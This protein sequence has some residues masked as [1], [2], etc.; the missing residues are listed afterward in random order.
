MKRQYIE[1]LKKGITETAL[2]YLI[3]EVQTYGYNIIKE[4]E[5]R[6]TGYLKLKGGTIYPALQRLELKGLVKSWQQRSGGHRARR[7]YR[8]T[9]KGRQFLSKRL[10]EWRDFSLAVSTLMGIGEAH[11]A[12]S[13]ETA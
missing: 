6:T 11:K 9:D 8:I 5:K 1:Q 13:S 2:L 12:I 4:L 7:Y 10:V 3:N